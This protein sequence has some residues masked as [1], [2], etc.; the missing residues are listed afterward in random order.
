MSEQINGLRLAAMAPGAR[1]KVS[2]TL[3]DGRSIWVRDAQPRKTRTIDHEHLPEPTAGPGA[4]ASDATRRDMT[5][6]EHP[7][8]AGIR[9]FMAAAGQHLPHAPTTEVD[10]QVIALRVR[11][12]LEET[13][14]LAEALGVEVLLGGVAV[15]RSELAVRVSGTV[16][17]A[18]AAGE[19]ADVVYV[20]KGAALALGIPIDEVTAEVQRA[21]MSKVGED[22]KVERRSD[23]KVVKPP[24][25]APADVASII[26][27]AKNAR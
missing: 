23:G 7:D 9:A 17:L 14:E 26:E 1:W 15:Q 22:G 19:I 12:V 2:R 10:A 5:I 4:E 24:G 21:N 27:R 13:F 25:F 8:T 3:A 11:L 16:D 20:A 6:P 18:G